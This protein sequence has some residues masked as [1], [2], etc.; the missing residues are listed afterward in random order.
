MALDTT[1]SGTDANS[2]ATLDEADEYFANHYMLAKSSA[3]SALGDD[4]KEAALR[5]AANVLETLPFTDYSVGRAVWNQRL[6]FP[7]TVNYDDDGAY[8]MPAEVKDAQC[9]QAVYLL[10]VDESAIASQMMGL[11][12]ESVAAGPVRTTTDYVGRGSLIAPMAYEL[13]R[14]YIRKSMTLYRA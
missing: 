12:H 7:L 4:Q 10:S 3:W 13:L 14:P 1:L 2:Y 8:Y 6:S 5:A 11:K 9:E